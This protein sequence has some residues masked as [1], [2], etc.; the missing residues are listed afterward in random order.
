MKSQMHRFRIKKTFKIDKKKS[1][2]KGAA[3]DQFV[4]IFKD[5][6]VKYP[7]LSF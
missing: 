1:I 3:K 7:E 4:K 2:G 6:L 5:E